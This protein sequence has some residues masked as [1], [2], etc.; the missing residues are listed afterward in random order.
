MLDR[1]SLAL[2]GAWWG[3]RGGAIQRA[4]GE[5]RSRVLVWPWAAGA[6]ALLQHIDQLLEFLQ[7]FIFAVHGVHL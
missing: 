6:S 3:G 1:S 7:Q 4:W 2:Q 5:G